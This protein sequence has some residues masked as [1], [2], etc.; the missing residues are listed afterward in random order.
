MKPKPLVSLNHLTVP[1]T[2]LDIMFILDKSFKSHDGNYSV[3][4]EIAIAHD[5]T[6]E[7]Q[8]IQRN[9]EIKTRTVF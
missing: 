5:V 4:K 1:V 6:E 3:E 7:I 9:G 8:E 2:V